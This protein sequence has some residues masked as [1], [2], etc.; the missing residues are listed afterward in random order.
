MELKI[1]FKTA[2]SVTVETVTRQLYEFETPGKILVNGKEF[3]ETKRVI[4]TLFDLKP[5][6]DY[7]ISLERNGERAE[8]SFRTDYEF[9][10]LNV[11]DVGAKGDG[12]QNDTSFIQAA[13]MPAD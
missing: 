3:G 8:V 10:T 4:F 12:I 9:V 13:I 2:R 1:V 7:N 11:K 5:D 6:M